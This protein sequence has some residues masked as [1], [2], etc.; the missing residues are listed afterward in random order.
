MADELEN[1]TADENAETT[2]SDVSEG[3]TETTS[4]GTDSE[5]PT[6]EQKLEQLQKDFNDLQDDFKDSTKEID[7]LTEANE[8]YVIDNQ[9]LSD[10]VV[11]F[12]TLLKEAKELD[13]FQDKQISSYQSQIL[14]LQDDIQ[15]DQSQTTLLETISHTTETIADG[16]EYVMAGAGTIVYYGIYVIPLLLIV[17]YLNA[18]LK[19]FLEDYR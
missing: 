12:K 11:E 17:Y 4:E 2:S 7:K 3:N 6:T 9:K 13:A 14:A 18:F 15:N 19:P 5:T 8:G 1:P 16:T 10:S